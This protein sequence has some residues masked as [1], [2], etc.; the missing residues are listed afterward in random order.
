MLTN[1]LTNCPECTD[2]LGLIEDIDCRITEISKG[3]Y[4]N[5]VYA[6]KT[7]CKID[8]MG[9]LLHYRRILTHRYCNADYASEYSI[10]AIASK[11]KLLIHK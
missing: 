2:I 10:E 9:D 7:I 1:R 8:T 5:I 3:I 6:V 4:S 11:V